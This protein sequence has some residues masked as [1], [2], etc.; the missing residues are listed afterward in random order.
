VS[1]RVVEVLA[2]IDERIAVCDPPAFRPFTRLVEGPLTSP[3]DIEAA[4]RFVR[5]AV[6]HD[7]LEMGLEPL[8]YPAEDR[9]K[10]QRD[11]RQKVAAAAAAGKTYA[12]GE[13]V[14]IQVVFTETS[15]QE[16]KYGYGLF[17]GNLSGRIP[18]N[19]DL[20]LIQLQVVSTFS[21]SK[22]G[23]PCY[24]SHLRYL[25]HLFGVVKAG[26]SIL[27][28]HPFA[29]TAI[30]RATQFP[31]SLFGRL[32]ADWKD[33]ARRVQEGQ[34]GFL[35]PPIL[36]I[37]LNNCARRDAIPAVVLDL[38]ESWA[39]PRRRVWKLVDKQKRARTL[40]E[41]NDIN[42][43]FAEASKEFAPAHEPGKSSPFRMLWDIFGAAAGGAITA[44]LAGGDAK[45]G[46]LT[47]AIPQMITSAFSVDDF[48][49]RGAFDLA[50]RVS[51][52]TALVRPMP[53][54]LSRF[55]T[56]S[57]KRALGYES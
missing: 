19:I 10:Q 16:Q 11:V 2:M 9:E 3:R 50:R 49:G 45:I 5:T 36:S 54:L 56:T 4:E 57:E 15:L 6:L 22:E 18:P 20:S 28:E 32:D 46:A 30:E 29:R 44:K 26:G 34:L 7:D 21:Q 23:E 42:D 25:Q 27:C 41:F 47:K 37:V 1:G 33:Y 13:P 51:E 39:A 43:E 31:V 38:R 52:A 8:P 35:L 53:E 24:I 55:L 48:F 40:R 12:P 14:G 17:R